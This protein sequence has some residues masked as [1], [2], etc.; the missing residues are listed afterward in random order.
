MKSVLQLSQLLSTHS[1]F[2][3]VS[4]NGH[5]VM[6]DTSLVVAFRSVKHIWMATLFKASTFCSM[7]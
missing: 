7:L 6:L 3:N 2:G 5:T 4:L 1:R